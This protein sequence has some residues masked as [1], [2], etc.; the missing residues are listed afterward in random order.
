MKKDKEILRKRRN[1]KDTEER[2]L[3]LISNAVTEVDSWKDKKPE[4]S[5]INFMHL[6]N[7]AEI[8]IKYNQMT[9]KLEYLGDVFKNH[10]IEGLK[11]EQRLAVIRE[12]CREKRF[13]LSPVYDYILMGARKYH[14][15]REWVDEYRWD[16]EDRL[17][18]LF[19]TLNVKTDKELA[20]EYLKVWSI[21]TAKCLVGD[22]GFTSELVLVLKG[23]QDA[24]KT[25]WIRALAPEEFIKTGLH[26]DPKNKDAVLEANSTWINELG[27]FDSMT[28]KVDHAILKAYLSKSYDDIRKHYAH[29]E[30]R[31]P[32]KTSFCASVNNDSFLVDDTGNRRYLVIET[33]DN[34]DSEHGID[35][36][37][38]WADFIDQARRVSTKHWLEDDIKKLQK[39]QAEKFR[40]LDPLCE[41]FLLKKGELW[42]EEYIMK[43]LITEVTGIDNPNGHQCKVLKQFLLGQEGWTQRNVGQGRYHLINPEYKL[44]QFDKGEADT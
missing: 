11:L 19:Q 21:Q 1:T 23:D 30:D 5:F 13:P 37:Q 10:E 35:M 17:E 28:R 6:M 18:A 26:I 44:N 36:Q 4:V 41:S 42:K 9:H 32:R 14:P 20:R 22:R 34:I 39:K 31:I 2:K 29:T 33:G 7:Y 27:E 8:Q 40:Q 38:Y 12:V 3:E 16:G 15:A 25:R 43:E 24:G